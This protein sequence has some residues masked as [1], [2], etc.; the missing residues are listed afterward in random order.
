MFG[1]ERY[2]KLV[3]KRVLAVHTINNDHKYVEKFGYG[4]FSG[5]F[6]PYS[7]LGKLA[8]DVRAQ[9]EDVTNPKILLDSGEEIWGCECWWM[10]GARGDLWLMELDNLGYEIRD[11]S[12]TDMRVN[13]TEQEATNDGKTRNN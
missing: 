7:A 3:G 10:D 2:D 13:Y 11:V 6:Y 9:G 12:I 1:A 5:H 4:T 8:D